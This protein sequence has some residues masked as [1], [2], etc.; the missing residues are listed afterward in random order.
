MPSPARFEL[1]G[2]P[3]SDLIT[4]MGNYRS[5]TPGTSV[6]DNV[7]V[8]LDFENEVQP[9]ALLRLD[10][11]LG[12]RCIVS[13]DDYLEGPPELIVE[14]AASSV[15]YDMHQKRRVYARNGVPEYIVLL[16]Y[17]RRLIWFVLREGVYEAMAPDEAGIQ[18]SEIFPGLWLECAS[19]VEGDL[20]RVL[21]ILQQGLESSEYE[22]YLARIQD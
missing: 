20:A 10:P 11:A 3:H 13:D 16:A 17:E 4:W 7:S 6:G 15:S 14:I 12:G 21:A 19:L 5:R 22:D 18:R 8:R 1:H 9:D 2:R